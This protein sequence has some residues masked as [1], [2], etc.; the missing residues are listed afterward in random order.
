MSA[1]DCDAPCRSQ[2]ANNSAAL[3]YGY[4][5]ICVDLAY[6]TCSVTAAEIVGQILIDIGDV[7]CAVWNEAIPAALG[8]LQFVVPYVG[9][10]AE[11][12]EAAEFFEAAD[13]V[14]KKGSKDCNL[15]C[16]QNA[17]GQK[18]TAVN[19]LDNST[20]ADIFPCDD[21]SVPPS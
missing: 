10:L 14:L 3:Q 17:S 20:W 12:A 7:I 21:E 8:I 19:P 15:A 4:A 1:D 2:L 13:Q 18:F 16:N 9:E 11:G 6:C 5:S